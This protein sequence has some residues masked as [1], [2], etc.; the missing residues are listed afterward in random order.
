MKS[1]DNFTLNQRILI[2]PNNQKRKLTTKTKNFKQPKQPRN[3]ILLSFSFL[4]IKSFNK[5]F[6]CE[7][8]WIYRWISV[9]IYLSWS[10]IFK[11]YGSA[12]SLGSGWSCQNLKRMKNWIIISNSLDAFYSFHIIHI[13]VIYHRIIWNYVIWIQYE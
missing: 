10:Y 1:S 4:F 6:W 11:W 2:L 13:G 12:I 9:C 7:L 8:G 3:A 5:L